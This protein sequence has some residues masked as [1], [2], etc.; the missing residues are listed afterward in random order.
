[1]LSK[2]CLVSGQ[3]DIPYGDKAI[4]ARRNELLIVI[5]EGD[6]ADSAAMGATLGDE[7]AVREVED[8]DN[9]KT[10][11][12]SEVLVVVGDGDGMELVRFSFEGGRFK[13]N[14]C[15]G[16]SE[17]PESDLP[18]LS[19]RDELVVVVRGHGK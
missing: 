19:N 9:S 15:V 7:L 6:A 8:A 13:H 14:F 12:N 3:E 5:R 16:F 1:L 4:T 17:V 18:F 11:T 2:Q 10:A